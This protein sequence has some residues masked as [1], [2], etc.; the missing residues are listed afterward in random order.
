MPGIVGQATTYNLPNYV[1]ELFNASP[2]DTPLLSSIGG[3]T[4]GRSTNSVIYGWSGYDLRDPEERPRLEGQDAPDGEHRTRYQV[5]NVVQIH[6]EAVEVSYTKLAT[7]GMVSQISD[8]A[9]AAGNV[10]GSNAVTDEFDWQVRQQLIQIARDVEYSFHRGVFDFPADNREARRTQGL[11]PSI[12]TNVKDAARAELS[13]DIVLDVMQMA[14]ENGGLA[15]EETRTALVNAWLKRELTRVFVE[16]AGYQESSRNVGG[17]NVTVIET[18]FGRLN[19]M[20][21]RFM[22]TDTLAMVSLEQLAPRFLEVPSKGFLFVEPLAKTG[23]ADS[24]QIYGEVGLE[25]GNER[26]HAKVTGLAVELPGS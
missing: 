8:Q 13:K 9:H 12:R 19:V 18:D 14:W 3:L 6:Q 11:I 22:P 1:G 16:E 5:T 2:Q 7:S 10:D 17:V 21:D 15:V 23:A 25:Y 20:L 26:T 24:A 4:G